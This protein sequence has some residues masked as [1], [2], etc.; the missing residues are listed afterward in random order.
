MASRIT[1]YRR[2]Q[3]AARSRF[4]VVCSNVKAV[5][6]PGDSEAAEAGKPSMLDQR[7]RHLGR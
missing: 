1:G 7:P 3:R 2:A 4:T 6:V 5:T